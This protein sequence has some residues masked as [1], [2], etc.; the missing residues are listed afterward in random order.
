MKSPEALALPGVRIGSQRTADLV[1]ERLPGFVVIGAM[2]CATTTLHEQ[3]ARQPGVFMSHPKEPNFFSDDDEYA[4]GLGWYSSLFRE[5]DPSALCGESSTH[6]TKLPTYPQTVERM[7]RALPGVK[8]IYVMRHPVDRL[9]SQYVHER[10]V[11]RITVGIREAIDRHT[12]LVDYGRYHMQLEPYLETFGPDR[13]LPVFFRR[14]T[15]HPQEELERI[16]RFLG[17]SR[18]PVWDASLKPQN[19]G[20]E[21]LRRSVLRQALL[22]APVLTPIRQ[23]VIPKGWTEP[24]KALWRAKEAPPA[25]PPDLLA[26]LHD[27]FDED[28]G[29]LGDRLGVRLDC[30]SFARVTQGRPIEWAVRC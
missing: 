15:Q 17:L 8:L 1:V 16:G 19:V 24:I 12:E 23:R 7:A 10:T 9:L 18:R 27:R 2:K 26:T 5:A 13:V 30:E 3:L 29:R 14:L 28:L 4:R 11:G 6:Y 25:L 22:R 21:R 20:S